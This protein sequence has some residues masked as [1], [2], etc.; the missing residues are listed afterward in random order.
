MLTDT[1]SGAFY[2]GSTNNLRSRFNSHKS[3]LMR[4]IHDN[5][6]LQNEFSSWE[7]VELEYLQCTTLEIARTHEQRQIDFYRGDPM[8]MNIG[9][10][11]TSP[12]EHGIP[13]DYREGL[14]RTSRI[15]ANRP[16]NLERLSKYNASRVFSETTRQKMRDAHIGRPPV[17]LETRQ[18]MSSSNRGISPET[19]A[20]IT[21]SNAAREIHFTDDA[22]AKQREAC[23][24]PVVIENIHYKGVTEAANALGLGQTTVSY[25]LKSP[26]FSEWNYL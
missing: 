19:R 26:K 7:N 11:T 17:S 16:E 13:E 22:R 5:Y 25:R 9:T 6:R 23:L 12:W 2:I 1:H 18:R 14:Q 3:K 20:K 8:F 15:A 4:G 10:G 21:A 24:R